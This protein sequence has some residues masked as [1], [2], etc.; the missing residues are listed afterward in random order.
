MS[1]MLGRPLEEG[2]TVHHKNGDKQDNR[3][4]NLELTT[5]S[6]HTKHHWDKGDLSIYHKKRPQAECH[7]DRPHYANG[8]CRNCYMN[9]AQKR[10]ASRHPGRVREKDQKYKKA[11]RD[12]INARRRA[13]RKKLKEQ[14]LGTKDLARLV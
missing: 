13:R 1:Q 14:G 7:P 10:Y 4:D 8:L 6:D 11:N 9:E 12:K 2:E 3:P 5:N